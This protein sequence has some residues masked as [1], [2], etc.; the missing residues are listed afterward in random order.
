MRVVILRPDCEHKAPNSE[1]EMLAFVADDGPGGS[2]EQ[3][4][5]RPSK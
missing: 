1:D 2:E 3:E 4:A 5:P